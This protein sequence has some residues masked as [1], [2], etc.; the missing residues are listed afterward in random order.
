MFKIGSMEKDTQALYLDLER[1]GRYLSTAITEVAVEL[2]GE[3]LSTRVIEAAVSDGTLPNP[4]ALKLLEEKSPGSV[5][6]VMERS[7]AL[8]KETHEYERKS[9]HQYTIRQYG[10]A[11]LEGFA[12]ILGISYHPSN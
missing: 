7:E 5:E 11:V 6:R 1:V 9:L 12:S 2:G 3:Q 4:L 8:Q 10:H